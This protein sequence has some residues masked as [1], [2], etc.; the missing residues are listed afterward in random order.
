M[1]TFL[2]HNLATLQLRHDIAALA[3]L[4]KIQVGEAHADFD[5]LFPTQIDAGSWSTRH[6]ARRHGCQF[7]EHWGNMYYLN[8]SL[9]GLTSLYDV[10]PEYVVS[11]PTVAAFQ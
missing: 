1:E 5:G 4:H 10:L 2:K 9:F 6:G 8:Q 3:L 11:R 7:H